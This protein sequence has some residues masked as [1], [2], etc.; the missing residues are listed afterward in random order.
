M[1]ACINLLMVYIPSHSINQPSS[2]INGIDHGTIL[3]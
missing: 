3:Y 2:I 1:K